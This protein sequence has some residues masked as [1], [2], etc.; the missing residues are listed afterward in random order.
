MVNIV[1]H[2]D[3]TEWN[4][5]S[6]MSPA[7][8]AEP[9]Q[10]SSSYT[11]SDREIALILD[12]GLT[13]CD[14]TT[15][16]QGMDAL[17][18]WAFDIVAQAITD[19][20]AA[21]DITQ[22]AMIEVYRVAQTQQISGEQ[23]VGLTLSKL[24]GWNGVPGLITKYRAEVAGR[25]R[26]EISLDRPIIRAEDNA[27]STLEEILSILPDELED[28]IADSE[29]N[30]R[31]QALQN[32]DKKISTWKLHLADITRSAEKETLTALLAYVEMQRAAFDHQTDNPT[33]FKI[34][35]GHFK[36]T[37]VVD[38]IAEHWFKQVFKLKR[39][40]AVRDRLWR[41]RD[42]LKQ[43]GLDKTKI[44]RE[45]L[46]AA[47]QA[48]SE[49]AHWLWDSP[50]DQQTVKALCR[51]FQHHLKASTST[52]IHLPRLL[53]QKQTQFVLDKSLSNYLQQHLN[54]RQNTVRKRIDRVSDMLTAWGLV[55]EIKDE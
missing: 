25:H 23:L 46:L 14:Y 30:Q 37:W 22:D 5:T 39:T 1:S 38:D 8:L 54:L 19:P 24:K 18:H 50:T 10:P 36:R 32:I 55:E 21:Q 45:T 34:I 7:M 33:D 40:S 6:W 43:H 41:V 28:K 53:L 35:L 13:E 9:A 29:T 11:P 20:D 42:L 51:W 49:E 27:T 44:E 17:W 26:L 47:T 48:L 15:F 3:T 16:R 4:L 12:E 52:Q 31:Q 2:N